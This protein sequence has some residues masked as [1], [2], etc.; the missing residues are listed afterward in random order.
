MGRTFSYILSDPTEAPGFGVYDDDDEVSSYS[1]VKY[2][3]DPSQFGHQRVCYSGSN[4]FLESSSS[5]RKPGRV[6]YTCPSRNDG[7]VH[8]W[9]WW[10]KA[11]MEELSVV[12][13]EIKDQFKEELSFVYEI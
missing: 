8:M 13:K 9:K 2:G 10:D 5:R 6:F 7:E 3:E 4:V 12:K 11:M 1:R